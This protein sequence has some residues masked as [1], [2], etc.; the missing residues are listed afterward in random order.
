MPLT[1]PC[2]QETGAWVSTGGFIQML[3]AVGEAI[4][5]IYDCVVQ[6]ISENVMRKSEASRVASTAPRA[7]ISPRSSACRNRLC[8]A[9]GTC[10]EG[11]T[12]ANLK[13]KFGDT[14]LGYYKLADGARIEGVTFVNL[15][16]HP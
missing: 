4:L 7:K 3:K 16:P 5:A 14:V 15:N 11:V 10:S 9:N 8:F 12:F 2:T 6:A 1:V 13:C